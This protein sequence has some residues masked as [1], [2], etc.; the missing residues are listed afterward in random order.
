[1]FN[2]RILK[3]V[4]GDHSR[5]H[6]TATVLANEQAQTVRQERRSTKQHPSCSTQNPKNGDR[7]GERYSERVKDI[8]IALA[9][10]R[11]TELGEQLHL[12]R[13]SSST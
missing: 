10:A 11:D 5:E 2:H 1:M 9:T 4:T 3:T 12:N 13:Q 7:S 8:G 6:P